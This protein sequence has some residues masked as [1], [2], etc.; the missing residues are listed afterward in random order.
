MVRL[1]SGMGMAN[2]RDGVGF[3]AKIEACGI[4]VCIG[5]IVEGRPVCLDRELFLVGI[6]FRRGSGAKKIQ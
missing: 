1:P 4:G 3:G 2:D 5:W 6:H